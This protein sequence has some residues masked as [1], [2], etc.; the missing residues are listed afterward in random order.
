M[1]FLLLTQNT[2][3]VCNSGIEHG[4]VQCK[5]CNHERKKG[6]NVCKCVKYNIYSKKRSYTTLVHYKLHWI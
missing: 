2:F 5:N 3:E 4:E 6:K 1:R